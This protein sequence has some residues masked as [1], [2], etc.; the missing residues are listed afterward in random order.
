MPGVF[1][2]L[3]KVFSVVTAL[4]IFFGACTLDKGDGPTGTL[5]APKLSYALKNEATASP[6]PDNTALTL[7]WSNPTG[8]GSNIVEMCAD[9]LF[10]MPY[11]D[12]IASGVSSCQ[13]TFRE[14]NDILIG[15]LGLKEGVQTQFFIRVAFV[16][17]NATAYSNIC[18]V[19][20]T[21]GSILLPAE[22]TCSTTEVILTKTTPERLAFSL[23]W[24]KNGAGVKNAVEFSTESNFL[25]PYSETIPDDSHDRQ[26]TYGRLNKILCDSLG[27]ESGV[28]ATLYI[29]I[30]SSFAT[31]AAYSNTIA[32]AVTPNASSP[33]TNVKKLYVCGISAADPW[34]F[35]DYLVQYNASTN[36]YAAIHYVQSQW[37]YKLYPELDNWD[38]CYTRSTGDAMSGT[39]MLGNGSS[40]NMYKPEPGRLYLFDVSLG[41]YT[42]RLTPVSVVSFTGFNDDWNLHSMSQPDSTRPVYTARVTITRPTTYRWQI[43]VNNDWNLKFCASNGYL[44]LYDEGDAEDTIPNGTYTLTVNLATCTYTLEL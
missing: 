23:S 28:D 36:S 14:L 18:A 13:F 19:T 31:T 43:V 25:M 11:T 21:P 3:S 27:M 4:L 29:R 33:D 39:L 15:N 10:K 26:Y 24:T 38:Y 9:S 41:E 6:S 35:E 30:V 22:L 34:N 42:Y 1:S 2:K 8:G 16:L 40:A 32:I 44:F 37:G 20:V 7:L 5:S 12:N 17:G